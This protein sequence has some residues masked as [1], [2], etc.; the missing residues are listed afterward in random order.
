MPT[1]TPASAAMARIV[2]A[3]YPRSRNS[4]RAVSTMT[5]RV[6]SDPLL[7]RVGSATLVT[8]RPASL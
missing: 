3:S 5:S 1:E 2:V 4:R 7:L 6:L 8:V